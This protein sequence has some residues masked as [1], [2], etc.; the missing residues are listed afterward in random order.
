MAANVPKLKHTNKTISLKELGTGPPIK[1][2]DQLGLA[3]AVVVAKAKMNSSPKWNSICQGR[4]I[5]CRLAKK[6]MNDAGLRNHSGNCGLDELKMIQA[7][8]TANYQMKTLQDEKKPHQ[9]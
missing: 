8:L 9:P 7:H 2:D 3:H 5:Q 1:K 4:Q 6:L